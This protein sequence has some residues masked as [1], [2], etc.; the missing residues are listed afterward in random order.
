MQ[1]AFTPV[2]CVLERAFRFRI[3]AATAIYAGRA[4][5]AVYGG[6]LHRTW[7]Y[8]APVRAWDWVARWG[9]GGESSVLGGGMQEVEARGMEQVMIYPAVPSSVADNT[10]TYMSPLFSIVKD[11]DYFILSSPHQTSGW[12]TRTATKIVGRVCTA[13]LAAVKR[14]NWKRRDWPFIDDRIKVKSQ[15]GCMSTN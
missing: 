6:L 2:P 11:D 15:A 10:E 14:Q 1:D 12:C 13:K 8:M 9:F 5:L 4:Q 7:P 3:E